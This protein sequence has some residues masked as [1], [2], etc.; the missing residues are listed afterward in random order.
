ME[1][2]VL[3]WLLIASVLCNFLTVAYFANHVSREVKNVGRHADHVKL[4]NSRLQSQKGS[5]QELKRRYDR[6]DKQI[7]SI[8]RIAEEEQ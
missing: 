8:K 1:Y 6:L 2:G 5:F 7:R 3:V 4:L